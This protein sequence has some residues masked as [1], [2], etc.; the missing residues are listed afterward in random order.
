MVN[1]FIDISVSFNDS[2]QKSFRYNDPSWTRYHTREAGR[3]ECL[4]NGA[5]SY[6]RNDIGGRQD[7]SHSPPL[8]SFLPPTQNS[9]LKNVCFKIIYVM[10][11]ETCLRPQARCTHK[12]C[13]M[14]LV[15]LSR[16]SAKI[17]I[18]ILNQVFLQCITNLR[19]LWQKTNKQT[20][21]SQSVPI[22]EVALESDW[23]SLVITAR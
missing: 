9:T 11:T 22:P 21:N 23:V 16:C 17:L 5:P 15:A 1:A 20:K 19:G 18:Y 8:P 4:Y 3:F 13:Y 10:N 6:D 7:S 14:V 2:F 12:N